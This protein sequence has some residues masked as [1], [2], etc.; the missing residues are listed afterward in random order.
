MGILSF[1]MHCNYSF[2]NF[3]FD[4][5]FLLKCPFRTRRESPARHSGHDLSPRISHVY[6]QSESGIVSVL[7]A[8]TMTR[9]IFQLNKSAALFELIERRWKKKPQ[10]T[11]LIMGRNSYCVRRWFMRP[12]TSKDTHFTRTRTH[13]CASRLFGKIYWL[14]ALWPGGDRHTEEPCW[15]Q[16]IDHFS[17]DAI[18]HSFQGSMEFPSEAAKGGT[19]TR[20]GGWD[21]AQ[22]VRSVK[23]HDRTKRSDKLRP[24]TYPFG[25]HSNIFESFHFFDAKHALWH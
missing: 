14:S 8:Q 2:C 24:Q 15:L 23:T 12:C 4:I 5:Y 21:C 9:V 11:Q 19:G 13:R 22:R 3:F 18:A 20:T 25:V 16:P 6:F 1:K 7:H 10:P 17:F